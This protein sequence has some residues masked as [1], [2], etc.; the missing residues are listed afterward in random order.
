M[1]LKILAQNALDVFSDPKTANEYVVLMEQLRPDVAV[2][3]EAYDADR[4]QAVPQAME[5]LSSLGYI[6][7]HGPYDDTDGRK[8]RHGIV[9]I[10]RKELID[11]NRSGRLVRVG[12]RN[13]AE[14]WVVDPVTQTSIHVFGVHLNDRSEAKRQAELDDLLS[15]VL[16]P[17]EPAIVAGDLN[18]IYARDAWN[19]RVLGAR[20]VALLVRLHLFPATDPT[21]TLHQRKTLGRLGSR[22]RRLSEMASGKTMARLQVSGFGDADPAH[23]PTFPTEVPFV[24]LDHIMVSPGLQVQHFEL[25]PKN[26]SD[27]LGIM[28]VVDS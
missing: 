14:C 22:Y 4:L 12:M 27:H 1:A 26:S 19:W 11:G 20:F 18:A 23:H 13:I 21:R 25:L 24:Q 16:Q 8:D 15:M 17:A 28:A 2:F 7:V 6:V 3:S 10:I 9:L 5:A